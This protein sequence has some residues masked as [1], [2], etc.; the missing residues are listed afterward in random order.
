LSD[1]GKPETLI[2]EHPQTDTDD[3]KDAS[4]RNPNP[5]S[6]GIDEIGSG[7]C[8]NGVH[9]YEEQSCQVDHYWILIVYLGKVCSDRREG[10]D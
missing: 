10:V 4:N 9:E 3:A 8:E 2:D 6:I 7:E 1:D 5:R